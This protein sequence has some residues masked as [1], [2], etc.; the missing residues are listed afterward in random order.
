MSK[1]VQFTNTLKLLSDVSR[2]RVLAALDG[3]EL[4]VTE[5]TQVLGL[6]Q[7]TISSQLSALK[8]QG[9]VSSRKDGQYVFYR[10]SRQESG[11]LE[12]RLL[13]GLR[14]VAPESDWYEADQQMLVSVLEARRE[15]SLSYFRDLRTQNQRSPGQGWES[16]A[17]GLIH[18]LH[19]KQIADLGCGIGRFA[20]MLAV[21]NEVTGVDSS[22]DQITA[23]RELYCGENSNFLNLRFLNAPMENTGLDAASFDLVIISHALHH[24]PRPQLALFEAARLLRS[25]GQV[26]IF[27]IAHHGEDWTKERFGDFW[28]GFPNESVAEWLGDAGFTNIRVELAGRDPEFPAFLALVASGIQN[29]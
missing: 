26:L 5:L 19:G 20:A 23:A 12:E 17:R 13:R 15:A 9:I 18:T 8:D 29:R 27:D 28:L 10:L 16:M 6:G 2:I 1:L 4:T 25:G 3:N 7:S 24:L 11:T 21:S 22:P 14:E